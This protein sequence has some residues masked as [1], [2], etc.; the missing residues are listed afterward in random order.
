MTEER[1]CAKAKPSRQTGLGRGG[2]GH[3]QEG[4]PEKAGLGGWT[5]ADTGGAIPAGP[6][7]PRLLGLRASCG[8]PPAGGPL[9][10]GAS[11]M[12]RPPPPPKSGSQQ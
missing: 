6:Q 11:S 7:R 3:G 1:H 9:L 2:H 8:S 4:L 10:A 12:I 5:G